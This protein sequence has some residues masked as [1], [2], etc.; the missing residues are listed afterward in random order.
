MFVVGVDEGLE[1]L[2]VDFYKNQG[3]IKDNCRITCMGR[4][5]SL[6]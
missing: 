6:Y 1:R 3:N 2:S 4:D 5:L